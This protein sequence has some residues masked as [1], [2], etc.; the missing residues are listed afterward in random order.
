MPRFYAG[1]LVII[2]LIL[3]LN[4]CWSQSGIGQPVESGDL[5]TPVNAVPL[6]IEDVSRR[7]GIVTGTPARNLI[8]FSCSGLSGVSAAVFDACAQRRRDHLQWQGFQLVYPARS[9]VKKAVSMDIIKAMSLKGKQLG[10]VSDN[11]FSVSGLVYGLGI[12]S[13]ANLQQ[14]NIALSFSDH[15]SDQDRKG[16]I[17]RAKGGE[18]AAALD[19]KSLEAFFRDKTSRFAG[20][21]YSPVFRQPLNKHR[22]D[23]WMPELVSS[24]AGRLVMRPEG[25]CL[26]INYS[27][28]ADARR[29][30]QF[31]R[32][33]EHMK[34]QEVIMQQLSVFAAGRTDTLFIVAD[35]PENGYWKM[36]E[37]FNMEGFAG[38]LRLIP[39]ISAEILKS[40]ANAGSAMRQL[41]PGIE[42]GLQGWDGKNEA[43]LIAR[44]DKIVAEK[45]NIEFVSADKNGFNSGLTIL[46]KGPNSQIFFGI[47]S[48]AEFYRR[49][50]G[51]AGVGETSEIPEEN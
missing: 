44:L 10:L 51:A 46:A 4:P 43:D 29:H 1:S 14:F 18:V 28:V 22:S 50:A 17:D 25:F 24:L 39:D 32:M 35:E 31:S 12:T 33:I 21:F 27:G 42:D 13:E 19:F 11:D 40:P 9:A 15:Q 23:P 49:L 37:A 8:I 30:G 48:F 38:D 45:H 6:S 5:I 26:V 41:N 20:S 47:S 36:D 3:F 2:F 34:F 16:I 7:R